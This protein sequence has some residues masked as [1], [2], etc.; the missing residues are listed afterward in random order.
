MMRNEGEVDI[1]KRL[2]DQFHPEI[3]FDPWERLRVLSPYKAQVQNLTDFY[4]ARPDALGVSVKDL[5]RLFQT[6][7]AS[8]GSE[9]DIVVI[10]ICR[11]FYQPQASASV[12]GDSAEA[13]KEALKRRIDKVLGF[14]QQPE[15]LNVMLSRARQQL[16]LVG[17][18]EY[19]QVGAKLMSEYQ[20][21]DASAS[22]PA[23]APVFWET[24]QSAF[25]AFDRATHT[26]GDALERPVILSA[27]TV[28]EAER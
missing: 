11:R 21:I 28:L 7:D 8:Q 24:L 19:F 15:R 17:D 18:F 22:M 13:R 14:M 10:S 2:L 20:Q 25:E 1:V 26:A 5:P 27:R 9:A 3:G 6:V 23:E 12:T 4:Y 16:I